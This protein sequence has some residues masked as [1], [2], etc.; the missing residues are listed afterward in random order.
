MSEVTLYPTASLPRW[1]LTASSAF[2]K[3][4]SLIR[5]TL[6]VGPYGSPMPR[7]LR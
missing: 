6:P 3:G 2:Y 1:S 4:T 5:N 7:D